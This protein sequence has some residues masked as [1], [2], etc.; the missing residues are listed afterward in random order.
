M[1]TIA[2]SLATLAALAGIASAQT[3]SSAVLNTLEVRQLVVSAEPADHIRLS[4]HFSAV[5]TEYSA[6]AARHREMS[7]ALAANPNR[8]S[9][10]M[11]SYC[12]RLADWY[13]HAAAVVLELAAHHFSLADGFSS[14]VPLEAAPFENGL[15]AREPTAI[16]VK[17]F[18]A[19]ARTR[20]DHLA[21]EEYFLEAARK[22]TAVAEDHVAMGNAY[23]GSRIAQTA[24]HCDRMIEEAREAAWTA[25]AAATKHRGLATIGE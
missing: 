7:C 14:F 23:R 6:E 11:A 24:T 9:P 16:D 15:G 3:E 17:I 12:T 25:R 20:A 5:S 4:M 10:G 21:L 18:E 1:K 2:L 19:R 22:H 13:A 8:W